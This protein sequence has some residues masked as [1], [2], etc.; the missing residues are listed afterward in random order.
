[1]VCGFVY[2]QS[3]S[4]DNIISSYAH[5]LSIGDSYSLKEH[6]RYVREKVK[7]GKIKPG[8]K[9]KEKILQ[10]EQYIQAS[11]RLEKC[12]ANLVEASKNTHLKNLIIIEGI[13]HLLEK[14]NP[15]VVADYLHHVPA[16]FLVGH[17][18]SAER[19]TAG[20]RRY[21]IRGGCAC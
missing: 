10:Y 7:S 20:D 12:L 17:D 9:L 1:M 14:A 4:Q 19:R 16:R 13:K 3:G 8:R 18:L 21:G 11:D 5:Y 2:P 6:H 15:V